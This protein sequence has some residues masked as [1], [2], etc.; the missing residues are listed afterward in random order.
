MCNTPR[1]QSLGFGILSLGF[2]NSPPGAWSKFMMY[3]NIKKT[4][5][6]NRNKNTF[7][8]LTSPPVIL[9]LFLK[10][11]CMVFVPEQTRINFDPWCAA[12]IT[13]LHICLDCITAY[14]LP[15]R[16]WMCCSYCTGIVPLGVSQGC[17]L[18]PSNTSVKPSN[19]SAIG[20]TQQKAQYQC[21]RC[22]TA[23]G[24][25]PV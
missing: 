2:S 20:A 6:T 7:K 21:N 4:K 16:P 14:L 10:R 1:I 25:I 9:D 23:K 12:A 17:T 3:K 18:N 15:W 24:P 19:T 13:L 11:C 8:K 5:T 22:N